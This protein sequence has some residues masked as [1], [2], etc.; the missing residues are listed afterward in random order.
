MSVEV[1]QQA[2]EFTLYDNDRQQRLWQN[3]VVKAW[4]WLFTLVRLRVFAPPKC[5]LLETGWNGLIL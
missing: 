2:P 1:G 4:S 3:F 5:A